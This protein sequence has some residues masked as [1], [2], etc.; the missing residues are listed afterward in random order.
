MWLLVTL[1][2]VVPINVGTLDFGLSGIVNQWQTSAENTTKIE[3]V[4]MPKV[5]SN[6]VIIHK[7]K[8]DNSGIISYADTKNSHTVSAKEWIVTV[9]DNYKQ[10]VSLAVTGL[11]L[12]VV[13][14]TNVRYCMKLKKDR[15]EIETTSNR[16]LPV[17]T[18]N[19]V[20]VPCLYGIF[21]PAI[22][23]PGQ[24]AENLSE[25][26]REWI[27]RHEE[28]HYE[29]KDHIWSLLRILLVAVYWF[30]PFVWAAAHVS[31]KDAELA[32]D[33]KVL[34]DTDLT[35]KIAYGKTL[36]C[37][38]SE[39]PKQFVLYPTTAAAGS[40]KELKNRMRKIVEE[41]RYKR[42][43]RIIL[44][45]FLAVSVIFTFSGCGSTMPKETK[46]SSTDTD[47]ITNVQAVGNSN[48]Q[49]AGKAENKITEYT[50]WNEK[51]T[52]FLKENEKKYKLFS[53]V[54]VGEKR[55]PILL[56][57]KKQYASDVLDGVSGKMQVDISEKDEPMKTKSNAEVYALQDDKVK[58]QATISCSSSGEW[59]HVNEGKVYVDTHH[60]LTG[61][62]W[63]DGKWTSNEIAQKMDKDY[64]NY[65]TEFAKQFFWNFEVADS[66]IFWNNT[67]KNRKKIETD[68]YGSDSVFR[69]RLVDGGVNFENQAGSDIVR[70]L[71]KTEQTVFVCD[72]SAIYKKENKLVIWFNC[73]ND[74]KEQR[75]WS[76]SPSV[77]DQSKWEQYYVI[78]SGSKKKDG[79]ILRLRPATF[80]G[81]GKAGYEWQQFYLT[82]DGKEH[83]TDEDSIIYDPDAVTQEDVDKMGVFIDHLWKNRLEKAECLISTYEY[84]D[85]YSGYGDIMHEKLLAEKE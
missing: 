22:Y 37:V 29:Q 73:V 58:K 47:K 15:K 5:Q 51:F 26:Q 83:V 9:Y 75:I 32:C 25:G 21:H 62:E 10:M 81:K 12:M 60:S 2:L 34:E 80:S 35:Q 65:D 23:L 14:L 48:S 8:K 17:Y 1:R 38:A 44:S 3:T 69:V 24:L 27:L 55:E 54:S 30:H 42:K 46:K 77:W 13:L 61:F 79:T 33:E 68:S 41:N 84:L 20:N 85:M 40:K 49:G 66:V 52:G 50:K 59:I 72:T 43:S 45:L 4:E 63:N 31:K 28:C 39:G 67:S 74:K 57:A 6:K 64:E 19:M 18:T 56:V 36:I 70:D 16:K 82:K 78:T 7:N 71:K 76:A 11:I 53:I